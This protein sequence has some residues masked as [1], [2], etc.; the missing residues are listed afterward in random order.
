MKE[1]VANILARLIRAQEVDVIFGV[2][3]KPIVPLILALDNQGLKFTLTRHEAGAGFAASGYS[4]LNKTL[5]VALGTSGPGGTNMITSA[6]QAK[7][8]HLPVL[9]IT[10]QVSTHRSGRPLPQ[11]GSTFGCDLVKLF[12]S[13]TL[14][15][16][17]V[18]RGDQFP[19]Y[20]QHALEK[21]LL[22]K[23]GPVHL[24]IPEDVLME[25]ID[26]FEVMLPKACP[27]VCRDI[28]KVIPLIE[29][30]TSPVL[31]VGKGVHFSDAY[32]EVQAV[33]ER[34]G[35]PV[36][37]TPGGK[38]C[39]PDS[40]PLFHGAFGLGGSDEADLLLRR[41]VDLLVI[42]GSKLC[43]MSAAGL[44]PDLYPQK[45]IQFDADLTFV[46]KSIKAP[47]I[48]VL[49]DIKANL[50][51]LLLLS[52][53]TSGRR[54][55]PNIAANKLIEVAATKTSSKVITAAETFRILR[56]LLPGDAIVFG[57]AGSH[58]F[59]AV[60]HFEILKTGT[61]FF[62]EVWDTMGHGIGFAVGA[63]TA[64]P[65]RTIVCI[66]GDG[67]LFMHGTEI[68]TAV[69]ENLPVIFVVL[70]NSSLDM[71]HKGMKYNVG[72][73]VGTVYKT[74]LNASLFGQSFG[75]SAFR[76]YNEADIKNAIQYALEKRS[77][78]V[79][80]VMVDEDEIPPTLKRG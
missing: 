68:S 16:A 64:R 25:E 40:H 78:T 3:G 49:G 33:A 18:E 65:D 23:K 5:G 6:A 35:I 4:L 9:F 15:S 1:T 36:I 21:A 42:I 63:Q 46:G 37:T 70:N 58:T 26:Q 54:T 32:E 48:P 14:F 38:G 8:F 51:E 47:T 12:E 77:P 80:E 20:F 44:T 50:Q 34:W 62:D 53:A 61:F 56:K 55:I 74:P 52:K 67:C 79:V 28:E 60:K 71:V 22:G 29:E 75:A 11:D 13:V 59:H 2:P 19:I 66:T 27:M 39:M 17:R 72:H 76:C 69:C 31:F 10:G 45:V 73:T 43:D 7:A 30:A 57:D 41:G 24:N